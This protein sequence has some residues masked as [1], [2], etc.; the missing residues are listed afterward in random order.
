M[1]IRDSAYT[2]PIPLDSDPFANGVDWAK[3]LDAPAYQPKDNSIAAT[4]TQMMPKPDLMIKGLEALA[5]ESGLDHKKVMASDN[6]TR[7]NRSG[8]Q[9]SAAE[10]ALAAGSAAGL[11]LGLDSIKA[12]MSKEKTKQQATSKVQFD[13]G[14][15]MVPTNVEAYDPL[16]VPGFTLP[17]S[18]TGA[19]E[20]L[21][22][23]Q[24]RQE[25]E[26]EDEEDEYE[27]MDDEGDALSEV[28]AFESDYFGAIS[29][30]ESND[31]E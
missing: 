4:Y 30:G 11:D 1:C 18:P 14:D 3:A 25:Y 20:T 17:P 16:N 2:G 12:E 26:D 5:A 6:Q 21:E 27:S 8:S 31:E 24:A 28:G 29:L 9:G 23:M 22:E 13:N 10:N 15:L 7:I 19:L